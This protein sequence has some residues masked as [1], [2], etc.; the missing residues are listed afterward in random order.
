MLPAT[1]EFSFKRL[2]RGIGTVTLNNVSRAHRRQLRVAAQ[3]QR[4]PRR[5]RRCRRRAEIQAQQVCHRVGG[6]RRRRR[7]GRRCGLRLRRRCRSA[8]WRLC[9][10][11]DEA[12]NQETHQVSSREEQH[13]HCEMMLR[14]QKQLDGRALADKLKWQRE[15]IFLPHLARV[16]QPCWRGARRR[17][18]SHDPPASCSPRPLAPPAG[19]L[20]LIIQ[21][22]FNGS[23]GQA[24]AGDLHHVTYILVPC[25]SC[26][27]HGVINAL[28][29]NVV[30]CTGL[31]MGGAAPVDGPFVLTAADGVTAGSAAASEP[32]TLSLSCGI[33][34]IDPS[35][36]F[37]LHLA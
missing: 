20:Q 1:P 28:R 7:G 35:V 9:E 4:R 30:T 8:G 5:R 23:W 27:D 16:W 31:T 6:G 26:V 37:Q 25:Q 2:R 3:L 24:A 22:S 14:I 29:P 19:Q 11:V 13:S 15:H 21:R 36:A 10:G 33:G 18:L 12:C 34:R 32:R 17:P